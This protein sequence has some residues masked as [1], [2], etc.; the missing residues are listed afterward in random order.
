MVLIIG[1]LLLTESTDEGFTKKER[2][3]KIYGNTT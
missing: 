1:F 3:K 2:A